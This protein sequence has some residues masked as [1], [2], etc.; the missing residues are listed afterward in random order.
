M[1]SRDLQ[2]ALADILRGINGADGYHTEA[3]AYV[4]VGGTL[5][6]RQGH[7]E[8]IIVS[9]VRREYRSRVGREDVD[10]ATGATGQYQ[11]GRTFEITGCAFGLADDP[12]ADRIEDLVDDIERALQRANHVQVGSLKLPIQIVSTET[13]PRPDGA[14]AETAVMTIRLTRPQEWATA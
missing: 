7:R 13:T 11:S 3:G 1:R 6:D 9:T 12:P 5:A 14:D 4:Q 10:F 2:H 8:Q